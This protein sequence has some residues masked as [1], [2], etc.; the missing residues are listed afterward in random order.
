MKI[1]TVSID[2]LHVHPAI[3]AMPVACEELSSALL[4][5]VEERGITKPLIVDEKN[6]VIDLDSADRLK[7][8]AQLNIKEIPVLRRASAEAVTSIL[9]ELLLR[10]HYTK[11]Q[12]T[13]LTWPL[14]EAAL[15]ESR[16][17]RIINL[18]QNNNSTESAIIALSV[19]HIAQRLGVSLRLF[20]YAGKIH[21]HLKKHPD[22][23][24]L[25]EEWIFREINPANLVEVERG[26]SGREST[27][28]IMPKRAT[29]YELFKDALRSKFLFRV[30]K[31]KDAP[32]EV[33]L[34]SAREFVATINDWTDEMR[35]EAAKA[36]RDWEVV[37]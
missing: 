11:S 12:L 7:A 32:P 10:R 14:F 34:L 28:G 26:I 37:G 22:Q 3:Q 6:F 33:R 25:I 31:L 13:Y 16:K 21:R 17:R 4:S 36:L 35:I 23:R 18:R 19:E 29:Q 30:R 8:A 20:K 27:L 9:D 15:A 5:T 2:L 24:E 1:E